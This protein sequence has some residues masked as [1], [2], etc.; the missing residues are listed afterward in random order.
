[1]H[2][3]FLATA[4][5]ILA[6]IIVLGLLWPPLWW[7]LLVAVP[8]VGIGVYDMLQSR[9]SLRRNFP[10]LARGRW[11]MERMRPYIR[12]YLLESDTDGRPISRMFRSVVY[13]RSKRQSETVPYGTCVDTYRLGYEWLGQSMAAIDVSEID[14]DLRVTVGGPQCRQ[15]YSASVL[16]ISAMSYGSLSPAAILALNRGARLGGFSHNTG[17]GGLSPHHL[18]H[19]GDLVWQIGTGYF[20]CRDDQGRFCPTTFREKARLPAVKMIELK[21]SQ[22]AKPGH[23]GILPAEKNTPEIAAIRDV[24][25]GTRI[26]SPPAHSAFDSPQGLIDFIE[27]LRELSDGKPVGI[28]LAIGRK[29]EFLAI[30]KAMVERGIYP[31]FITVD[32]G[33]GGTGAA[34]IEY[35]NSVGMPL[36]EALAFVDDSLTGFGIRQ[37]IRVIASGKIFTGFHLVKNLALGAD[38]CNSARGMM[39]ALGCVQSLT[40]N[41]NRCPTGVATQNPD[42]YRGLVVP[43]KAERVCHF[44]QG[45]LAATAELL[46]SAGLRHPE[47]LNRTHLYRRVSP[48]SICRYDEIFPYVKKGCFLGDDPPERYALELSEARADNFLPETCLTEIRESQ[49]P[50][51]RS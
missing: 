49:Q 8:L 40:C 41:T 22:G 30:G 23:G 13:Q 9:H 50:V 17:E 4:A 3:R 29:S 32:G 28:K 2:R 11:V 10:L 14:P 20:G 25:S 42:L 47:E 16:N 26:E 44:H 43:D 19:G 5:S 21:I 1:M 33:E 36:R 46:S 12:Q 18:E 48:E 24:P 38:L 35:A 7:L 31:D 27:E 15:P 39:L 37:H 6:V 34:P 45:T 51:E